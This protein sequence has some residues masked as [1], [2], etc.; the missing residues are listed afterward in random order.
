VFVVGETHG[1]WTHAMTCPMTVLKLALVSENSIGKLARRERLEASAAS[2]VT[3]FR[4]VDALS[5]QPPVYDAEATLLSAKRTMYAIALIV[6]LELI[7]IGLQYPVPWVSVDLRP[8]VMYL[9]EVLIVVMLRRSG[10]KWRR[11]PRPERT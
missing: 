3:E 2:I 8:S 6:R 9:S 10:E 11:H 4:F 1:I 5:N 7:G